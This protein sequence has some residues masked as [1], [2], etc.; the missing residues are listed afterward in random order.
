MKK[1]KTKKRAEE[2]KA[3]EGP[4]YSIIPRRIVSMY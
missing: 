3:A 4:M 1:K 2:E